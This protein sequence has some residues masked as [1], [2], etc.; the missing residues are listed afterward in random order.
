MSEDHY[1]DA[2]GDNSNEDEME[3]ELTQND[4]NIYTPEELFKLLC[5][6][7]QYEISRF[8]WFEN[9]DES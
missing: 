3:I 8:G 6:N 7:E 2:F 9:I 4:A 1:G 5:A